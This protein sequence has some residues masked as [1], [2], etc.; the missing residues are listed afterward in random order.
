MNMMTDNNVIVLALISSNWHRSIVDFPK[1]IDLISHVG[2]SHFAENGV[3]KLEEP[4][5]PT[6]VNNNGCSITKI[7]GLESCGLEN[8]REKCFGKESTGPCYEVFSN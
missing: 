3:Y 4:D 1:A 6:Y 2:P 7:Q 5:A 8:C